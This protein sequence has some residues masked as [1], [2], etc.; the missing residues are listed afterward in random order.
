MS[1]LLSIVIPAAP[2]V[3]AWPLLEVGVPDFLAVYLGIPLGISLI[4]AAFAGGSGLIRA[5]RGSKVTLTAPVWL[6]KRARKALTT[7]PTPSET[8][9]ASAQW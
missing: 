7:D 3:T 8:G 1:D 5:G 6:G 4:I 2:T 9:G